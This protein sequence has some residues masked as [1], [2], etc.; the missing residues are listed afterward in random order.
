[1]SNRCCNERGQRGAALLLA[2]TIS[3][4]GYISVA[5][6]G[7]VDGGEY[8][9]QGF[10]RYVVVFPE[11]IAPARGNARLFGER[12]QVGIAHARGSAKKTTVVSPGRAPSGTM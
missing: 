7:Q 1:M 12:D 4:L 5:P 9:A 11:R 2:Q 10:G 8:G 6:G 3:T